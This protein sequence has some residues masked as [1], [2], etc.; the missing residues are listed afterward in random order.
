M[1]DCQL[2]WKAWTDYCC[3]AIIALTPRQV[4]IYGVRGGEHS[5]RQFMLLQAILEILFL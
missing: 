3:D 5:P 1:Q 2:N 4:G